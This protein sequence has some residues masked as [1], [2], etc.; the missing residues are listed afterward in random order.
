MRART[1]ARATSSRG[2]RRRGRRWGQAAWRRGAGGGAA[3]LRELAPAQ[4]SLAV[5]LQLEAAVPPIPA[6]GLLE[7]PHGAPSPPPPPPPPPP[8]ALPPLSPDLNR[9]LLNG[10][11]A[12]Q[13][14]QGIMLEAEGLWL[15]HKLDT[16]GVELGKFDNLLLCHYC[17]TQAVDNLLD[18]RLWSPWAERRGG[19]SARRGH[20]GGGGEG[21]GLGPWAARRSR[22]SSGRAPRQRWATG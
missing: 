4:R 15:Q 2:G 13:Q 17:A 7:V 12:E 6:A 21:G 9:R 16:T 8:P 14:P 1:C 18:S 10:R 20:L 19:G 11:E 5:R 22:F 3:H